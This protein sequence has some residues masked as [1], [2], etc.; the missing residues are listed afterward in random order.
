MWLFEAYTGTHTGSEAAILTVV[1]RIKEQ[2]LVDVTF[3]PILT[4][5]V[6]I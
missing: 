3:A 4:V 6:L 2:S 1:L 5:A